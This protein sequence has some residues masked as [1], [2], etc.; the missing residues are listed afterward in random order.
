MRPAVTLADNPEAERVNK[1]EDRVGN[2]TVHSPVT[3]FL[4][5][6]SISYEF[7]SLPKQ[8]HQVE[9]CY[10]KHVTLPCGISNSDQK[11][12]KAPWK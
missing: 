5:Q 8:Y 1:E 9:T 10:F 6:V 12:Q 2:L 3:Y 7:H 11:R 4:Q